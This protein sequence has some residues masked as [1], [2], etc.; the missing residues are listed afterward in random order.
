MLTILFFP[1]DSMDTKLTIRINDQYG[2]IYLAK[3]TAG[4]LNPQKITIC[5][6]LRPQDGDDH[7]IKYI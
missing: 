2:P 5:L 6:Q 7:W 4:R 3:T 1:L